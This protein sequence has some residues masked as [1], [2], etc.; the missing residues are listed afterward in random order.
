MSQNPI[1][2]NT[3]EK[4]TKEKSSLAKMMDWALH[5]QESRIL[6]LER[7]LRDMRGKRELLEETLNQHTIQSQQYVIRE[8][9]LEKQINT[10]KKVTMT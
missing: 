8:R 4:F 1:E 2:K 9:T 7:E 10:L 6:E 3:T 5:R